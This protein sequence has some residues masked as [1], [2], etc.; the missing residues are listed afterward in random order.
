[1][2]VAANTLQLIA[3]DSCVILDCLSKVNAP[4]PYQWIKPMVER[5][6]K[7]E[8]A[9]VVSTLSIAETFFIRGVPA[10]NQIPI[11]EGFFDYTWV[12]PEAAGIKIGKIAR[13][14]RRKHQIDGIDAVH[15]ATALSVDAVEFFLTTDGVARKNKTPI[16]VLDKMLSFEGRTLRI[17]TAKQYDDHLRLLS[18]PLMATADKP[19]TED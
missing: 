12:R 8:L 14:I 10:E 3:W 18:N 19:K 16:L 15:L 6:E 9:I 7:E 17:M 4:G 5:A 2:G 1:M 11:I 13:D